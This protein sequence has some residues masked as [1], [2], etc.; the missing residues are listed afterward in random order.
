MYNTYGVG[1]IKRLI[2]ARTVNVQWLPRFLYMGMPTT[3]LSKMLVINVEKKK[4]RKE[5]T[6]IPPAA[7]Y[8]TK[9]TKVRAE[10]A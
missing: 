10:A 8:L 7:I 9:A 6:Y 5:K 3:V 2:Q 1:I 4:M